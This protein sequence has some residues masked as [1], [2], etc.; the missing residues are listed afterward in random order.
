M[1]SFSVGMATIRTFFFS[2]CELRK[3]CCPVSSIPASPSR[4]HTK[5]TKHHLSHKT[6]KESTDQQQNNND[7]KKKETPFFSRQETRVLS[8]CAT[9]R[10]G[11]SPPHQYTIH[12][13][14]LKKKF[15]RRRYDGKRN[16]QPIEMLMILLTPR[17]K[18]S[19]H[20]STITV[21]LKPVL[22]WYTFRPWNIYCM[23]WF[24]FGKKKILSIHFVCSLPSNEQ[25]LFHNF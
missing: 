12:V 13:I 15:Q 18:F 22:I 3:W 2:I 24:H 1:Y 10:N 9:G 25:S 14:R 16:Y 23:G 5:A 6:H 8:S 19:S 4:S 7:N 11:Y 21:V 17:G 20:G